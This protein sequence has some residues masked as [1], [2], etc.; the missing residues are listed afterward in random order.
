MFTE[1]DVRQIVASFPE[2]V[3][4]LHFGENAFYVRK[5]FMVRVRSNPDGLV[6]RRPSIDEKLAL[7]ESEPLKFFQTPHFENYP[8]VLAKLDTIDEQDL[9]ELIETA[10]IIGAPAKLRQ[11]YLNRP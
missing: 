9:Y 1:E 2:T 7:I 11:E 8:Y 10:W 5:S 6:A 4:K 3:E